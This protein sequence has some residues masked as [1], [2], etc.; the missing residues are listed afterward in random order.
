MYIEGL[1][2]CINFGDFLASTLPRNRPN[3][4]HLVI[5]TSPEDKRTRLLARKYDCQIVY[6]T[7]H[8]QPNNKFNKAK[9]INDGLGACTKKG[10]VVLLDADVALSTNFK[11]DIEG[12]INLATKQDGE[13]VNL[14]VY[15]LHRYMCWSRSEWRRFLKTG[16]HKWKL[17][18]ERRF[19]Q[20]PAG[21][22][23]MWHIKTCEKSYPEN[24]PLSRPENILGASHGDI[25][26]A[27]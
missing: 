19:S 20:A 18:K 11:L 14:T 15:G 1:L 27:K 25:A 2:V 8:E 6:T 22:F 13:E 24:Y 3:F 7:R 10:W 5:V 21:Y 26:F 12:Q 4:D 9:A 23:Q 16:K 17:D